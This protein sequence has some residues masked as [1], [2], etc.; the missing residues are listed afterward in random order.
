MKIKILS[1]NPFQAKSE[2]AENAISYA[3]KHTTKRTPLCVI[4]SGI[5]TESGNIEYFIE[6]SNNCTFLRYGESIIW[7][8]KEDWA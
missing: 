4:A 6:D 5:K 8:E 7:P 1:K 3:K 2:S